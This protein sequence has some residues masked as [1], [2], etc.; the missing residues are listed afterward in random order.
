ML[1]SSMLHTQHTHARTDHVA[2]KDTHRQTETHR[3]TQRFTPKY[4]ETET[5]LSLL[6]SL[7]SQLLEVSDVVQ[8]IAPGIIVEF[9]HNAWGLQ[10]PLSSRSAMRGSDR[11]I[12]TIPRHL[13]LLHQMTDRPSRNP[14]YKSLLFT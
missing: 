8:G 3:N 1:E 14:G 2:D 6:P 9:G 4:R 11:V 10:T 13:E 7:H 5:R 12:A